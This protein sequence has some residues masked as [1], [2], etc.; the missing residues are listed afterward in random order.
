MKLRFQFFF[1]FV[2]FVFR[3]VFENLSEEPKEVDVSTFSTFSTF[4][5]VSR[6]NL[7]HKSISESQANEGR[8]F[9]NCILLLDLNTSP[10]LLA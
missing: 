10:D 7:A 8:C 2:I 1:F 6:I 4:F 5:V 3:V 9:Y